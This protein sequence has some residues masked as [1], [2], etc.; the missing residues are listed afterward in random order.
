MIPEG[1]LG[2]TWFGTTPEEADLMAGA[3]ASVELVDTGVAITTT[4][5]TDPVNVMTKVTQVSLPS[6]EQV[7]K[8][9]ILTVA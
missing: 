8:V 6:F 7:D 1:N 4:K 2:S 3:E 9:A 5:E